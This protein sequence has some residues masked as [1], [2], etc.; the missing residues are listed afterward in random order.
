MGGG[1]R[2]RA[3][4]WQGLGGRQKGKITLFHQGRIRLRRG[5]QRLMRGSRR[6]GG[7]RGVEGGGAAGRR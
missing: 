7:R 4:G 6:R 3:P 5:F 2:D 1:R